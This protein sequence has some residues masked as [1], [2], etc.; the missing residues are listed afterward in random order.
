MAPKQPCAK[1]Q[2][3]VTPTG[4]KIL[5]V[6]EPSCKDE[7]SP[8]DYNAGGYLPVK[9]NDVFNNNRYRVIRKLGCVHCTFHCSFLLHL[10][11]SSWGHFST[12]WLVK[13]TQFVSSALFV[14]Y[15]LNR[16]SFNPS[17][18]QRHSALKVVKSAGRYAETAR[19]EIKLLSR[20]SAFSPTHQGREHIVS[21]LDSFSHQGPEASHVCIVFEPLGENLLALIE[22]HKKKGVPRALVKVIARQILLGLEYLHDECD[23]VHTD[24]KPENICECFLTFASLLSF[25]S[26][27]WLN[28]T[29]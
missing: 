6:D 23:L 2:Y 8:A 15:Y 25:L 7:E 11:P 24:I 14:C 9:V 12:V 3:V 5:P 27:P 26:H 21:F 4:P 10:S 13:D 1:Y 20:V 22:R 16:L 29:K 19:D 18:T 17:S 28:S